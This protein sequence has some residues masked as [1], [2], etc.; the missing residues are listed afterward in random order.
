MMDVALNDVTVRRSGCDK[1]K[2]G[3]VRNC[4]MG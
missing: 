1:G 2:C 3:Q 4:I